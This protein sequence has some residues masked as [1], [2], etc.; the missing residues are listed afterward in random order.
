MLQG[1]FSGLAET[2]G[3]G[4]VCLHRAD[5]VAPFEEIRERSQGVEVRPCSNVKT[6]S[7]TRS[8]R[9]SFPRIRLMWVFTV[10]SLRYSPVAISALL[11]PRAANRKM[12]RSRAVRLLNASGSAGLVAL[13]SKCSNSSRV[14]DAAMTALP[15]WTVRMAA[16]R[17]SG[18]ASFSTNPLAPPRMARVAASSRSNVV[19]TMMRGTL[20]PRSSAAARM[21]RVDSIPTITGMRMSMSTT[22]G[23]LAAAMAI[24]STPFPAS[25]TNSR[26][27]CDD[28]S[29]R[30][31]A[32][33]S[34][35]SSTSPTRIRLLTCC[36]PRYAS[37]D[38][39]TAL[40][41]FGRQPAADQGGALPHADEPVAGDRVQ[42]RLCGEFV[43][44]GELEGIRLPGQIQLHF[45]CDVSVT[46]GVRQRLLDN[47]VGCQ[48]LAGAERNG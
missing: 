15:A 26:S 36:L 38:D 9:P 19:R 21:A 35:W 34:A 11:R 20:P 24:P 33:K 14:A 41:G 3:Q 13:P 6:T 44:D 40:T 4:W 39:E 12:S 31:P 48:L 8:R 10:A 2:S 16:S 30:M 32:R 37:H 27:T 5:D 28:T 7:W 29:M 22:S 46:E 23:R 1:Y 43:D 42:C 45:V 18:S 25:P 17:N 47:S